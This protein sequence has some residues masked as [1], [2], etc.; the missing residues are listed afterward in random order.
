MLKIR[1]L[2]VEKNLTQK[3]FAQKIGSTNKNIWAYEKGLA[4]PPLDVLIEMSNFFECSIDY[5]VGRTDDLGN[6]IVKRETMT[7]KETQL[8]DIFQRIPSI[9]QSQVIEYAAYIAER[10]KGFLSSNQNR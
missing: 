5:L 1:E 6:V 8:L 9:Y 4:V 7:D 2:R 3:D 10:Q